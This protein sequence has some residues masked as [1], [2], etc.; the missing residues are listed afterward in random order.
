MEFR[1]PKYYRELKRLAD[2]EKEKLQAA[3]VKRST[4]PEESSKHQASSYK[5][6]AASN[7][8]QAA[9]SPKRQARNSEKVLRTKDRGS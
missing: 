4:I 8:L 7:K 5:H 6:Q 1:H 2:Q 3:S 9:S